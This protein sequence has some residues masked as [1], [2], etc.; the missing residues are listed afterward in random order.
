MDLKNL[1]K[2]DTIIAPATSPGMG[3]IAVI[4]ISGPKAIS[5]TKK[6]FTPY[7][8]GKDLAEVKTHTAH[9]GEILDQPV[10]LEIAE[11][12]PKQQ[13]IDEVLIN[14]F[15]DGKSFTGEE[16]VEISCHGSTYIIQTIL[17]LFVDAG[18]RAADAGEFTMRAYRNGKFDLSQAEAVADL[19]HSTS[20]ASSQLALSQL[21]GGVSS[22]ISKLREQLLNFA[23]LIELELDFSEEDVEFADRS[24]FI[25][26]V[27]SIQKL[28][29]KLMT[30][31]SLGNS[32][33]NG[34]PV[35][36][37][38]EPNVG[39]STLLNALL[40]EDRAIVSSIAGTTRDVIEDEL[41]IEGVKFRFIDTAGIRETN[42]EIETKGIEKTFQKMDM[43][44]VV[45]QVF[46]VTKTAQS[47]IEKV[48]QALVDKYPEK[49][50]LIV[51]NKVDLLKPTRNSEGGTTEG[52]LSQSTE[53]CVGEI[54][55]EDEHAAAKRA[56]LNEMLGTQETK[57]QFNWEFQ[58]QETITY[59]PI[60]AKSEQ[61]IQKIKNKLSSLVDVGQL[62]TGD[63]IISNARHYNSLKDANL[64]LDSVLHAM[65]SG[66]PGDLLAI[67]IRGALHSLG[68][69][70]GEITTDDLLG[71][72]FGKFCIG[73]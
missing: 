28:V 5:Y 23:S 55:A 40:E 58:N 66:I 47:E 48:A 9:F 72:I 1:S 41:N 2:N 13:P 61:G 35:A 7:K 26:L 19:I 64:S 12:Q 4:R 69:I 56:E 32:I 67:D 62:N 38:G 39:K 43:A 27:G 70:T 6:F 10:N 24:E 30:S 17:Q 14:V 73:K 51:L 45:M 60:S 15:H 33:K 8:S 3:A 63:I 18:V 46:D 71:N 68:E 59:I 42:D 11:D 16:T 65:E 54:S 53:E 44:R 20:K 25:I 37:V 21:K 36:I 50:I 52:N 31:F 22:E 57:L 34:L 49:E 29:G